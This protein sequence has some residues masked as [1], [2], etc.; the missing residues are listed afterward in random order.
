MLQVFVPGIPQPQGSKNAYVRGNRAVL[1]EANKKLPAWRQSVQD[2][3]EAANVSC[4]PMQGAIDAEIIFF[5]PRPKSVTR[6]LPTVKPDLDKLIR[7]ILDA[8]T[9]AGIYNDDSQVI[10]IVAHKFYSDA[11]QPAGALI[12]FGEY[13]GVSFDK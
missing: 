3:L 7:G 5:I 12:T 1:V 2:Q 6:L 13:F 10:E 9:K 11:E 8:G 4:E